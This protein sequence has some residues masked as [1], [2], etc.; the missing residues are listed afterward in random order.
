IKKPT[1]IEMESK[2]KIK[3]KSLPERIPAFGIICALI[4]V[5]MFS[6]GSLIAKYFYAPL[7][8]ISIHTL[9]YHNCME[10]Y[11]VFGEPGHRWDLFIRCITGTTSLITL[12]T[13]YRLMLLSDSTTIYQASPIFVTV[14]AYLIL[15]DRPNV[16][17]LISGVITVSGVFIISKPEFIFGSEGPDKYD[18]RWVGLVLSLTAAITSAMSLINLRKLKSTPVPVVVMWYSLAVVVIGG[19][20]LP[21][22]DRWTLPTGIRQWGLLIAIGAAGVLNQYFQTTAFKYESPGP[23][24]VTRSFNIVLAFIWEV[25]IFHEPVQ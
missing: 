17:Q 2:Q 12:Y 7:M 8:H 22:L 11:P 10:K 18:K 14:F 9:L 5:T 25:T 20:V 1:M 3:N 13:S 19:S 24:S 23:I 21:I 16:V 15:R 4:G 6:L